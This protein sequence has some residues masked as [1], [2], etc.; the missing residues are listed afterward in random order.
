MPDALCRV[1]IH[2]APS[3][4]GTRPATVDLALPAVMAVGE[5]L[6]SIVD[7]VGL[8]GEMLRNWRLSRI[9]GP[10][11]DES[12]TLAQNAIHDGD[13]LFLGTSAV[14]EPRIYD[15]NRTAALAAGMPGTRFPS[16]LRSAGCLCGALLGTSVLAWAGLGTHGAGRIAPAAVAVAAVVA[17]V[18]AAHRL[19]LAPII[20]ATLHL[21]AVLQVTVLGFLIVPAGPAAANFFLAAAAAASAGAVLLRAY[22][23]DTSAGAIIL[24][25]VVTFAVTVSAA[26]GGAVMWPLTLPALGAILATLGLG[27]LSVAPRLSIA[28]ADLTPSIPDLDAEPEES[29]RDRDELRAA[30]GHRTLTGLVTGCC[31]AVALGVLLVAAGARNPVTPAAIAFTAAI[32]VA[33]ALRARS[34]AA[35]H[36][37]AA[38]TA[39]GLI[40]MAAT[41]V[42]IAAWL[43]SHA[44]WLGAAAVGAGLAALVPTAAA[45]PA[46]L[47]AV[48]ALE[49]GALAV[50]V[51]LTCWLAGIFDLV[52]S[53]SLP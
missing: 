14:P 13:A 19:R 22:A 43:P 6:P 16:R 24:T 52:R 51:P 30:H 27:V 42:L 38:L 1:S 2:Y 35:S 48:D 18:A 17:A 33:L 23:D 40:G 12:M 34:Y 3:A 8:G 32:G 49:Y 25:A 11:L 5:L 7:A 41:F 15:Q 36:C 46:A 21:T 53:L 44:N 29:P 28:L 50:V 45:G 4:D 9:G 26:M 31:G 10:T 47:R 39:A 37:R 20:V